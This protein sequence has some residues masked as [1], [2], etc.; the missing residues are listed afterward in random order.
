MKPAATKIVLAVAPVVIL[1]FQA[2]KFRTV[3]MKPADKTIE[4]NAALFA[5]TATLDLY[6]KQIARNLRTIMAQA[7]VLETVILE[8]KKSAA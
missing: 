4:G 6:V 3:A 2:I 8:M 5:G 1:E 7:D